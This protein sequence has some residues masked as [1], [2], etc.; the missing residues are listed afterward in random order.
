MNFNARVITPTQEEDSILARVSF[1][2]TSELSLTDQRFLNSLVLRRS[3]KKI[4]EIGVSSGCASL[5]ILNAI[6]DI[7]S[8]L[9]SIDISTAWA[10][11]RRFPV[12]YEVRNY[13]ELATKWTL[14]AGKRVHDWMQ[15]IGEIDFVLL[16]AAHA[17]PGEILDFIC[18]LPFLSKK[19]VVVCHNTHLSYNVERCYSTQVL[20]SA[21]KGEKIVPSL[22]FMENQDAFF[23]IGAAYI[24]NPAE[25][26]LY[27]L[28]NLLTLPWQY[29]ISADQLI[30]MLNY[31][32][33]YYP[34]EVTKMMLDIFNTVGKR[35]P[36]QTSRKIA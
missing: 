26:P 2:K 33:S 15:T 21:I 22:L 25:Q 27:E 29:E 16:D 9:F 35:I 28:L 36:N 24:Q 5:V 30:G 4:L 31:I 34:H 20:M 18:V 1:P 12:G 17:V 14:L 10:N 7:H 19:C 8:H 13:T 3:P 11:N 6:R 23:N 32:D